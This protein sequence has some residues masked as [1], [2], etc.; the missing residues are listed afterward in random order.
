MSEAYA[1]TLAVERNAPLPS[2][3]ACLLHMPCL[4]GYAG[5]RVLGAADAAK[6]KGL[7]Y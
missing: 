2:R 4:L 7:E 1:S 5:R 3:N 6:V